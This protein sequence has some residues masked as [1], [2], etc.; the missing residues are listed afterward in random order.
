MRI[1]V[2]SIYVDDQARARDF[3]TRVLGFE[4]RHDVPLGAYRWL[5]VAEK[6]NPAATEL[7][8]EPDAH[9]AVSP[10]RAA[11]RRDGVPAFSFQVDDLDAEHRRLGALGVTFV[12]TPVD[13]GPARMAVLDDG[14][15]NLI[16]LVQMPTAG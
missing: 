15:G 11:L 6:G 12:R 14:C 4:L 13:A 16:Q 9:P 7:L 2:T 5:T 8:L 10:Y 3:Y 1:Y